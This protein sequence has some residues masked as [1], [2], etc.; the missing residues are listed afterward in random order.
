MTVDRMVEA[1]E[2]TVGDKTRESACP[3]LIKKGSATAAGAIDL[4]SP[5]IDRWS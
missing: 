4:S 2:A 3:W 1:L 5:I